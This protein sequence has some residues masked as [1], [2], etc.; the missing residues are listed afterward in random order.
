MIKFKHIGDF[1][2]TLKFL[3]AASQI[4]FTPILDRYGREGVAALSAATPKRS[5][6]TA[7]SWG[8]KITRTEQ[9][10]MIVWTNSHINQGISIALLIQYGHGTR[11]GGYVRGQDYI[12]P[13]LKPVFDRIAAEAWREVTK[14]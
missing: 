7:S 8:Y 14:R 3:K 10:P 6:E 9:G 1:Q 2:R 5:G 12:N 4:D 11:T 13:A